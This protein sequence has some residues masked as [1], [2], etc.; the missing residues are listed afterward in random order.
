MISKYYIYA[1]CGWSGLVLKPI[2][3]PILFETLPLFFFSILTCKCTLRLLVAG[4]LGLFRVCCLLKVQDFYT[5]F[6]PCLLLLKSARVLLCL[7][8]ILRKHISFT[9]S[10]VLHLFQ[11]FG[12]RHDFN[13]CIFSG[14]LEDW[15]LRRSWLLILVQLHGPSNLIVMTIYSVLFYPM[16]HLGWKCEA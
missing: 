13:N 16:I 11:G 12:L 2:L 15:L 5:L 3:F 7:Y 14:N 9:K 1:I 10:V 6:I 8:I 4:L